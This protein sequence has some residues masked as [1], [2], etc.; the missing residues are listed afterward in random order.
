MGRPVEWTFGEAV[1]AVTK[2]FGCGGGQ[3][4][5]ES[6]GVWGTAMQSPDCTGS[7]HAQGQPVGVRDSE[8]GI[9][10]TGPLRKF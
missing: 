9:G 8:R 1:F 10:G 4:L 5:S 7:M 6:Y 3:G 2:T